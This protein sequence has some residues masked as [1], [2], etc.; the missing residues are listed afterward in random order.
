M[1]R[2]R[3]IA[4]SRV[5]SEHRGSSGRVGIGG[6]R[7]SRRF[8]R[9]NALHQAD[10]ADSDRDDISESDWDSPGLRR[11]V[12]GVEGGGN[13]TQGRAPISG[14]YSRGAERVNN[15][16]QILRGPSQMS[17]RDQWTWATVAKEMR[18]ESGGSG[19]ISHSASWSRPRGRGDCGPNE[20]HSNNRPSRSRRG[21]AGTD[22]DEDGNG[23]PSSDVL[24]AL[25]LSA[26]RRQRAFARSR[27]QPVVDERKDGRSVPEEMEVGERSGPPAVAT[28]A[29]RGGAEGERG[30]VVRDAQQS[31]GESRGTEQRA[32]RWS[33]A[34][35]ETRSTRGSRD[36]HNSSAREE[37]QTKRW[38]RPASREQGRERG[39]ERGRIL[40]QPAAAAPTTRRGTTEEAPHWSSKHM[41]AFIQQQ[42][43]RSRE[44]PS[45]TVGAGRTSATTAGTVG[46][47]D[48]ARWTLRSS[49]NATGIRGLD[50]LSRGDGTG[51]GARRGLGRT[52]SPRG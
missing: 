11:S 45:A 23:I 2:T 50:A 51:T 44:A 38:N 41:S 24:T 48:P 10:T 42:Q 16:G 31:A 33:P 34:Q 40:G 46:S 14:G 4:D 43:Y 27:Q 6:D 12:A 19:V 49:R 17:A 36:G 32:R 39:A 15:S 9:R 13:R 1:S 29:G 28:D 22:T 18:R 26:W 35:Q 7:E 25:G 20:S 3:S 37:R 21:Q 52:T 5:E 47:A 30:G 8:S